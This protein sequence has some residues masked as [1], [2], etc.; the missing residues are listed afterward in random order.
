M[1]ETI[2]IGL[3]REERVFSCHNPINQSIY[4]SVCACWSGGGPW[5]V[6]ILISKK[7][8][9]LSFVEGVEG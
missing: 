1:E 3:E 7:R 5:I 8:M 9:I 2:S 4:M 6:S